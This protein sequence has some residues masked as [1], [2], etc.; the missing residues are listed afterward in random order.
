M[1][2]TVDAKGVLVAAAAIALLAAPVWQVGR[3]VNIAPAEFAPSAPAAAPAEAQPAYPAVPFEADATD[4]P[5]QAA[6]TGTTPQ[7]WIQPLPSTIRISPPNSPGPGLASPSGPRADTIWDP[8]G[9]G[10]PSLV[11]PK[12]VLPKGSSGA[13]TEP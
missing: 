10:D 13:Q 12:S 6:P 3:H 8:A 2:F 5:T 7:A 9:A 4:G 11:G 1:P